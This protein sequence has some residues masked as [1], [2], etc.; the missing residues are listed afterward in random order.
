[1]STVGWAILENCA[2]LAA[3]CVLCWLLNNGWGLMVLLN[4]NQIQYKKGTPHDK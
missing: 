3:A 1:M 2:T 4:L